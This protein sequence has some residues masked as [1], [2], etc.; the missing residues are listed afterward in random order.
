MSTR[1]LIWDA[2]VVFLAIF[3]SF[4]VPLELVWKDLPSY[5]SYSNLDT[6][7]TFVFIA[8]I[9]VVFNTEYIDVSGDTVSDRT[10]IAKHYLRSDFA[11]DF[12]SSIPFKILG[13]VFD[14][15]N[16]IDIL[17]I[18]KVIRIKRISKLILR[19]EYKEETKAVSTNAF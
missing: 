17:K 19:L 1:K 9:G 10:K 5:T 7:I 18:L 11:I 2:F 12:I 13:K 8:D 3:N 14:I 16:Q 15:F 6:L 4:A